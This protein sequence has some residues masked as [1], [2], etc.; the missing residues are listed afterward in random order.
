MTLSISGAT[1]AGAAMEELLR[2][3]HEKVRLGCIVAWGWPLP[4]RPTPCTLATLC[5]RAPAYA[6]CESRIAVAGYSLQ[7][8]TSPG[9]VRLRGCRSHGDVGLASLPTPATVKLIGML[10][11]RLCR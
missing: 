6:A 11:C 7:P 5:C 2:W 10:L 9:A 8:K 4:K 1:Q 3:A